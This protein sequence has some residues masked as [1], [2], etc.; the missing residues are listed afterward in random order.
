MKDLVQK[1]DAEPASDSTPKG[2]AERG[3]GLWLLPVFVLA[4]IFWG[5]IGFLLFG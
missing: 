1:D 5:Y 2:G 3:H 4:V